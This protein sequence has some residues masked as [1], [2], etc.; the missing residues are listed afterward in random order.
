MA[1]KEFDVA[2][3]S[4]DPPVE[5]AELGNDSGIQS[6]ALND[7]F[8]DT[9]KLEAFMQ[10]KLVILVFEDNTEGALRV[11]RPEVNGVAQPIIRG[12]KTKIKRKYVEA[13]ARGISTK[14]DQKQSD[15]SNPA[16]LQMIPLSRQTYPFTVLFDPDELGP[17]WLNNILAERG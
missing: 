9:L 12:A 4:T 1:R 5:L 16:S 6:V 3:N 15:P 10:Q 7:M 14:F 11:I 13:L 2:R 8:R 17:E